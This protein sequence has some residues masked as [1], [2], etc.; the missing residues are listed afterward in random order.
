MALG[1]GRSSIVILVMGGAAR[2]IGAGMVIGLLGAYLG[3]GFMSG[4][5]FALDAADPS[6]YALTAGILIAVGALAC[7]R[8]V[9][10]AVNTQPADALRHE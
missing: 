4:F 8:P 2:L 1:A 5:L 3:R 9:W 7:L 10:R 6:S